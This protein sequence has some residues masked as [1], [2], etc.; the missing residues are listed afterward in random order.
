MCF[1][2]ETMTRVELASSAWQANALAVV[3][4]RHCTFEWD[5]GIEPS[6]AYR[7]EVC[8]APPTTLIPQK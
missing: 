2:I 5:K 7:V 6:D 1:P 4:H 3:L 8:R